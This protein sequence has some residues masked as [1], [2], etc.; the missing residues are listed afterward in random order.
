[1]KRREFITLI[2]GAAASP[3][4]ARAQQPAKMKRIAMVH[5]SEP[6]ANLVASYHR[7]YRGFFDEVSRLGFAEGKNLVVER[8]SAGGQIDRWARIVREVVDTRPDA[9]YVV[10][11][12]LASALKAAT[13]TIPIVTTSSDP[14]AMGLVSNIA[15]PG[16]NITGTSVDA[17]LGIWG[18]RIGLLKEVLPRLSGGCIAITSQKNWEGPYGSAVRQ[19]AEAA[20]IVLTSVVFFDEAEYPRIFA[21]FEQVRPDALMFSESSVFF[22][23]RV[24]IVELVAKHRLPAMYSYREFVEAG[25]LMSYASNLEELGRS[26]GYQ[27]GQILNGTNPGDIPFNQV[28]RYELAINLKTAKSLGLEFSTTLLGSADLVVE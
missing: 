23:N 10:D 2:G 11:P 12:F 16:G 15:R 6:V 7:F 25:G 17:G 28:T 1:M 22:T 14:V 8:Y 26:C 9:I 18:K 3:I 24:T 20:N 19:A 4:A 27:V 13:T 5:P 21:A